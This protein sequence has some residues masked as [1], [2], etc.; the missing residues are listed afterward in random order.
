MLHITG[1][2]QLLPKTLHLS[3]LNTIIEYIFY[4]IYYNLLFLTFKSDIL[5]TKSTLLQQFMSVHTLCNIVSTTDIMCPAAI[6]ITLI[7]LW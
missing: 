3:Y 2:N 5:I 6:G 4:G 7:I 1:L